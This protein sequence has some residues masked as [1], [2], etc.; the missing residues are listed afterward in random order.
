MTESVL[1]AIALDNEIEVEGLAWQY[2]G[3]SRV[4]GTKRL[5]SKILCKRHNEALSGLD[6]TAL[7]LFKV[8]EEIEVNFG[9]D[10]DE[11][12][13]INR[14]EIER[15]L[16]KTLCGYGTAELF[17]DPQGKKIAGWKP[18]KEWLEILFQGKP[19]P[20]ECGMYISYADQGKPLLQTAKLL[21]LTSLSGPNK[22]LWGLRMWLFQVEFLL[23]MDTRLRHTAERFFDVSEYRPPAI[24]YYD[25]VK[26]KTVLLGGQNAPEKNVFLIRMVKIGHAQSS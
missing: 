16:L 21:Q 15:W 17:V 2:P 9:V 22:E 12:Y 4:I 8:M 25:D 14:D 3:L 24:V 20:P 11:E 26:K 23:I 10:R 19:F 13:Q 6:A 18:P 5:V 7:R 1:K